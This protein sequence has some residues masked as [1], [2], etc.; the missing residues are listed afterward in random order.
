MYKA[1]RVGTNATVL[2]K[3]LDWVAIKTKEHEGVEIPFDNALAAQFVLAAFDA[4]S[5]VAKCTHA[6]KW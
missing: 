4:T 6:L 2:L 1:Q 5:R 3:L